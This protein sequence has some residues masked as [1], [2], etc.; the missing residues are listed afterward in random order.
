MAASAK[1]SAIRK[2]VDE[3]G[4]ETSLN[5]RGSCAHACTKSL[6]LN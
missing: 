3:L 2:N 1:I 6:V 4:S 5:V